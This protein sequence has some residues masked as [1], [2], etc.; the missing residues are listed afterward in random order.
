MAAFMPWAEIRDPLK[1]GPITFWNYEAK[2]E[3]L[4][5]DGAIRDHLKKM[6]RCYVDTSGSPVRGITMISHGATD[7]RVLTRDEQLAVQSAC[8][9]LLFS[10]I[11]PQ[12][13]DCYRLKR[14]DWAPPSS[15]RFR[16]YL[17]TFTL[18]HDYVTVRAGVISDIRMLKELRFHQ[19]WEVGG[20]S[21]SAP[22]ELIAAFDAVFAPSFPEDDR[23]RIFRS[24]EWF[25]MAQSQSDQVHTLVKV[26]MMA[27]AFETLLAV[28]GERE[29]AKFI[30]QAVEDRLGHAK[31][32]TDTRMEW[33]P[34][35]RGQPRI[36]QPVTLTKAA[37]WAQDFY[38]MRSDITHGDYIDPERAV[39]TLPSK[40]RMSTLDVAA[41]VFGQL[42]VLELEERKCCGDKV[43]GFLKLIRA[44]ANNDPFGPLEW[45]AWAHGVRY[46]HDF[47]EVHETLGWMPSAKAAEPDDED[48]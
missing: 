34:P 45:K 12:E 46:I 16:F 32:L 47:D 20:S 38:S 30:R 9:A 18:G 8:D 26:V 33:S 37:W 39:F 23:R 22:D 42:L 43:D 25:R 27:T 6:L 36:Q 4:V 5:P 19:P 7:F 17:Q 21:T 10:V 40:R 11:Y 31:M 14:W 48:L 44:M 2:V 35:F 15:D 1:L 24:L 13:A 3:E 41:L 28:G 29:K